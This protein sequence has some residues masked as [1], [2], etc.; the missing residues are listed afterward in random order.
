[1]VYKDIKNITDGVFADWEVLN[2][3]INNIE[4]I[5]S[6]QIPRVYIHSYGRTNAIYSNTTSKTVRHKTITME[7]G[8]ISIKGLKTTSSKTISTT[9]D[10]SNAIILLTP[11]ENASAV[12]YWVT[13]VKN[14]SFVI[15]V[16]NTSSKAVNIGMQWLCIG[17][18]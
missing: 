8:K 18:K 14:G 5:V 11:T 12:N 2:N 1:M 15:N 17:Y 3:I 4:D 7:T 13:K 6:N 10:V 16:K 9:S